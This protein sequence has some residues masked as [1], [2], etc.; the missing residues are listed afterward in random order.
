MW[1]ER[2]AIT[3]GT[4][5]SSGAPTRTLD[6]TDTTCITNPP[7][8]EFFNNKPRGQR[9][10][11]D[12]RSSYR[13]SLSQRI[14]MT[15]CWDFLIRH[16]CLGR[17]PNDASKSRNNAT[18]SDAWQVFTY[19]ASGSQGSTCT[20]WNKNSKHRRRWT[21]QW[22]CTFKA[23]ASLCKWTKVKSD[24]G[25]WKLSIHN[26]LQDHPLPPSDECLTGL[27]NYLGHCPSKLFGLCPCCGCL[28]HIKAAE[29]K[30]H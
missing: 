24:S 30:N 15:H 29:K 5:A 13:N 22:E 20:N 3:S 6:K 9:N 19:S 23:V 10:Q 17:K 18:E 28:S 16:W 4:K 2:S 14:Q 7:C 8:T 27:E 12:A 1:L 11:N 26:A 21:H 25:R